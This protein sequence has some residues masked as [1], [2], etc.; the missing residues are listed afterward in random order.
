MYLSLLNKLLICEYGSFNTGS[1]NQTGYRLSAIVTNSTGEAVSI[2]SGFLT[3]Y[4][5]TNFIWGRPTDVIVLQDGS[6][7][8]SDDKAGTIYRLSALPSNTAVYILILIAVF[9][10]AGTTAYMII[11]N[12]CIYKVKSS[13]NN[14][15]AYVEID[16]DKE[17]GPLPSEALSEALKDK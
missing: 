2:L 12:F 5:N 6:I 16:D 9:L 7:L 4:N 10:S 15:E 14:G 11:H 3:T 13:S 8:I 1:F 17:K